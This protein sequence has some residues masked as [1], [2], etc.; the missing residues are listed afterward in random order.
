MFIPLGELVDVEKELARLEKE[1][2]TAR[3]ELAR[4]QGKLNNQGFIAKAP[5]KLIDEEK[6]KIEKYSQMLDAILERKS[7]LKRG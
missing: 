7:S 4:A 3:A 2:A 6:A 1:E 5:Q